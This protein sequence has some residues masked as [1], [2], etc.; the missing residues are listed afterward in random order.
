M[1]QTTS[2]QRTV[3]S[4]VEKVKQKSEPIDIKVETKAHAVSAHAVVAPATQL[5]TSPGKCPKTAAQH[6]QDA[7]EQ[8][9]APVFQLHNSA[10]ESTDTDSKIVIR[11]RRRTRT[12]RGSS[13]LGSFELVGDLAS[14]LPVHNS[15]TE[16]SDTDPPSR[17][18]KNSVFPATKVCNNHANFMLTAIMNLFIQY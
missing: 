13:P 3:T 18:A 1:E 10:T 4:N 17:L 7:T 11:L 16:N 9:S 12:T 6:L 14:I 2:I 8:V 15:Q 5:S